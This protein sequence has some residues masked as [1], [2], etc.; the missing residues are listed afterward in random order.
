MGLRVCSMGNHF[1]TLLKKN[2]GVYGRYALNTNNSPKSEI[3]S[4]LVDGQNICIVGPSGQ[5]VKP[6]GYIGAG[7]YPYNQSEPILYM[8]HYAA[9]KLETGSNDIMYCCKNQIDSLKIKGSNKRVAH[10][11]HFPIGFPFI[12]QMALNDLSHYRPKSIHIIN[13]NFYLD[14]YNNSYDGFERA[15]LDSMKKHDSLMNFQFT[16]L[17]KQRLNLTGDKIFTDII[18][19]SLSDYAKELDKIYD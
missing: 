9:R 11:P 6:E 3:F 15:P 1:Q 17:A 7:L 14:V 2:E 19:M 4:K 10:M 12:L 5:S 8:S 18:S 16:K 13:C